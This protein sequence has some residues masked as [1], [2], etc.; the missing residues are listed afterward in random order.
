MEMVLSLG[1]GAGATPIISTLHNGTPQDFSS[2]LMLLD[3]RASIAG[4]GAT[5][6]EVKGL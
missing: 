6:I 1:G 5:G 4:R 3:A 2:I